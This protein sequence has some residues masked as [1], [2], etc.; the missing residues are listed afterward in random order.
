VVKPFALHMTSG[1]QAFLEAVCELARSLDPDELPHP[2]AT[3]PPGR[4]FRAALF[5]GCDPDA[6]GREAADRFSS[7][8][9]D[10]TRAPVYA[11]TA[12]ATK[13]TGPRTTRAAAWLA[14]EGLP[15]FP[16]LPYR[17]RLQT[18]GF[19]RRAAAFT[20][21]VQGGPLTADA[22]RTDVSLT[23]G[24]TDATETGRSWPYGIR[25]MIRSDRVTIGQGYG[26]FRPGVRIL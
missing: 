21:T 15:K 3:C 23:G 26:Q 16:C 20:W 14:V 7:P 10:P 11:L 5:P 4:A 12:T 13:N 24:A 6:A 22:V 1:N 9:F 19:D 8:G 2:K 25:A 17:C 18:C